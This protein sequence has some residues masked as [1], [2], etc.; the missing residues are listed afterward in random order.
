V[1]QSG[2]GGQPDSA[3]IVLEAFYKT[4]ALAVLRAGIGIRFP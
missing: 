3:S 4:P 2:G 1:T